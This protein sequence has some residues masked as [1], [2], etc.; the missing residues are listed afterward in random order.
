MLMII[1]I[2]GLT[3]AFFIVTLML[4]LCFYLIV[5]LFLFLVRL[6]ISF[7]VSLLLCLC[8]IGRFLLLEVFLLQLVLSEETDLFLIHGGS[9]PVFVV[10]LSEVLLVK[11]S[12]FVR[13]EVSILQ[14]VYLSQGQSIGEG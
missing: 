10:L 11:L 12:Y 14:A 5:S 4:F 2:I 6:D 1:I 7:L 3:F 8:I 13:S 9:F